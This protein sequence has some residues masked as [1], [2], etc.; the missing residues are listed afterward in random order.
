MSLQKHF[1]D[2]N[3]KIR[4]DYD[5]K[6]ELA[7]K[8]DILLDKL[9]QNEELPSFA[10]LNQ[11]SYS[12]FTG[13]EPVDDK[14]Y[15]IDVGLRF[16]VNCD[17]YGPMDLKQK[18][19]DILKNH[20]DMGAEIKKPCVTVTYKKDG[21]AA[22]HVDLVIYVYDDCE[23]H[24]SQMYLARGKKTENAVWEKSDPKGLAN[25]INEAVDDKNDRE[26]FR[27]VIRY[28][29]RWKN[30]KFDSHGHA[31]PSSIGLTLIA[32]DYFKP[33]NNNGQYSDIDALVSLVNEITSLFKYER[34]SESGK[35]LFR[36]R[37]PMPSGLN[38]ESNTDAFDKMTDIQM[39]DFKERIVNNPPRGNC[40]SGEMET[41]IPAKRKPAFR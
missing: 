28:L 11:G 7:D 32:A 26:Q 33:C 6:S 19:A 13:V 35:E 23:D 36:I 18:V 20:T 25:Y 34:T 10:A 30:I 15:D 27:R 40:Q 39:T 31:E 4:V 29:K 3:D 9:R 14:E 5:T 41:A 37:Y 8:R 12:M 38:F 24:N 22:Y 1:E 17:E 16:D 2:F 21:E